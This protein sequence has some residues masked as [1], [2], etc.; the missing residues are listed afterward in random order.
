MAKL[1]FENGYIEI[2]VADTGKI[3]ITIAA[4][5]MDGKENII[6]SADMDFNEFENLIYPII[7]L[8]KNKNENIEQGDETNT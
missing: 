8:I 3:L 4:F 1:E 6:N 7:K 5:Q 2:D